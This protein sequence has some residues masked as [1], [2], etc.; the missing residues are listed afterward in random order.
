MTVTNEQPKGSS[1]DIEKIS[2][3]GMEYFMT[4][5]VVVYLPF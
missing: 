1:S 2:M 5:W 4:F 3:H